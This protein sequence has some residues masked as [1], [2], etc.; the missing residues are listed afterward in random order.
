MRSALDSVTTGRHRN[1]GMKM[2]DRGQKDKDKQ[3]QQQVSKHKQED[4]KKQDKARPKESA[5]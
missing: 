5:A 4:Q 1:G 3:K 2:G